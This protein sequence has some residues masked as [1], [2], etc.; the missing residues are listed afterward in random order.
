MVYVDFKDL[1]RTTAS[2]KVLRDKA[3]NVAEN[4]KYNG[5]KR[6]LVSMVYKFFGRKSLVVSLKAQIY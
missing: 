2:D 6:V 1:S 5:Y 3:F 4:P